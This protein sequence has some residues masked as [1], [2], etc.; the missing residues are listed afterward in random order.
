ML[1][2]ALQAQQS[3]DLQGVL[4]TWS[5]IKRKSVGFGR[6]SLPFSKIMW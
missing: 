4:F 1:C 6:S 2:N 5:L 3:V